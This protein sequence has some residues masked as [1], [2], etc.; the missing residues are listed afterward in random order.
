MGWF[1]KSYPASSTKAEPLRQEAQA[2]PYLLWPMCV[3]CSS[4]YGP[5]PSVPCHLP[6]GNKVSHTVVRLGVWHS[7][8]YYHLHPPLSEPTVTALGTLPWSLPLNQ[9]PT[10]CSAL[11]CVSDLELLSGSGITPGHCLWIPLTFMPCRS[12][13]RCTSWPK[14]QPEFEAF[15]S[16]WIECLCPFTTFQNHTMSSRKFSVQ[17]SSLSYLA[18]DT[19]QYLVQVSC[20]IYSQPWFTVNNCHQPPP[21]P[22]ELCFLSSDVARCI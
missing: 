8:Y 4:D 11:L 5:V 18:F 13:D 6:S 9:F 7:I 12:W 20:D 15:P 17:M 10:P 21:L 16:L 2:K 14:F 3:L 1:C 22:T 19:P